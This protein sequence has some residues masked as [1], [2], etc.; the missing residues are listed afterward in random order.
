[1]KRLTLLN[2]GVLEGIRSATP[3]CGFEHSSSACAAGSGNA[4]ITAHEGRR[5]ECGVCS[6]PVS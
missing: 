3:G 2:L 6:C 4:A 1:M 5:R